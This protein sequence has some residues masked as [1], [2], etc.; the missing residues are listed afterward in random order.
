M[1]FFPVAPKTWMA[2]TQAREATPFFEQL[3]PAMTRIWTRN[4]PRQ[5]HFRFAFV[6]GCDLIK[7]ESEIAEVKATRRGS[8]LW[9]GFST[10]RS[11]EGELTAAASRAMRRAVETPFSY[12]K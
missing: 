4:L 2:G 7:I 5:F 9:I 8:V 11:S 6:F 10:S 3:C 1:S 12:V